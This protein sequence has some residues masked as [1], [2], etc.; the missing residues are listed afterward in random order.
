MDQREIIFDNNVPTLLQEEAGKAIMED[1][2]VLS[3][4]AYNAPPDI[5]V[6]AFRLKDETL[7]PIAL[8][9]VVAQR[10]IERLQGRRGTAPP[11]LGRA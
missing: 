8:N 5:T 9:S 7:R 11:L 10:L 1:G 3:F 4:A 6:V 2:E